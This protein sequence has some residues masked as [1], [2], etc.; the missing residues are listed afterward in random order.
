VPVTQSSSLS[1]TRTV[2]ND[3]NFALSIYP[4]R[5]TC[6]SLLSNFGAPLGGANLSVLLF[7]TSSYYFVSLPIPPF[8]LPTGFGRSFRLLLGGLGED[9]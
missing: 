5:N 3:A 7:D 4:M 8:A 6:S 9:G 2:F 1:Y